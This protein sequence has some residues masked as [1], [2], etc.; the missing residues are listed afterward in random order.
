MKAEAQ[1]ATDGRLSIVEKVGFG[2]GDT[3]SNILYQ[4]W[5]F[6]LAKFY[7]DVYMLPPRRRAS[8]SSSPASGTWSS[9]PPSA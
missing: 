7:T 1:G 5:S 8:S 4:A 3:A 2:L 6:F 9:T